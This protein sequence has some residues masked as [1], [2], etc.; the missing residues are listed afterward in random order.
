VY[1]WHQ[2]NISNNNMVRRSDRLQNKHN[3]VKMNKKKYREAM[4]TLPNASGYHHNSSSS[5]SSSNNNTDKSPSGINHTLTKTMTRRIMLTA[6]ITLGWCALLMA[7]TWG[8]DPNRE[9]HCNSLVERYI[10]WIRSA[11][12]YGKQILLA[13][14]DALFSSGFWNCE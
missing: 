5:S 11:I 13:N 8:E 14:V 12:L 10:M 9:F 6:A 7:V 4:N 2:K 3:G 1:D